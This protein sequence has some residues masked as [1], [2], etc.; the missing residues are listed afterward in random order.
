MFEQGA[1]RL[2]IRPTALVEWLSAVPVYWGLAV[3][4]RKPWVGWTVTGVSLGLLAAATLTLP[5]T[6]P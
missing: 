1:E 4:T 6:F 3:A 5:L 2:A